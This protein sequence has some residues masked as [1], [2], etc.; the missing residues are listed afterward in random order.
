MSGFLQVGGIEPESIVDGPGF[1][2]TVFVQGCDLRCP[3]CHNPRLQTFEGGQ[4]I[5]IHDLLR[6]IASNPLL[7]GLTLSGG[8]PFTQAA[9]CA[10]L[11]EGVQTLGL[12]VIT[13]TGHPWETLCAANRPDWFRL[14]NASSIIVD[15]P[16][17]MAL[18]DPDLRFRGS[19]N[20]RL[21]DV[22]RSLTA[23]RA[24]LAPEDSLTAP[25]TA[26]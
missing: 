18:R 26:P 11:A 13:F 10:A 8:D 4:Q 20:Q 7:D 15:G 3:G 16:F 24:I 23:G 25:V 6:Q 19:S 22:R 1:R 12:S 17:I 5:P 9:S 2:Y 14:I 21:I